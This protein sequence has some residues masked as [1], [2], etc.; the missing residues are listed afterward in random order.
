MQKIRLQR[1]GGE[2]M[3]LKDIAKE[4][5][6]SISTVS[7][8]INGNEHGAASKATRDRIWAVVRKNGYTPNVSAQNLKRKTPLP[9]T[10]VKPLR[11]IDCLQARTA[12][13]S[14]DPFFADLERALEQEAFNNNYV[15]KH[16]FRPIDLNSPATPL[17]PSG[18]NVCGLV[19]FGRY[20]F[21]KQQLQLLT[22]AYKNIIYVG[23]NTLPFKCDQVV[24]DGY[25]AGLDAISY[26]LE[27]G[28]KKIAYIG[29]QNNEC[30]FR[31]YK[32]ALAYHNLPF[33]IRNTAN[34]LQST[35]GGHK[36]VQMLLKQ[37]SDFSAVFCANDLTAIGAI[38]AFH[39]AKLH[40]PRDVSVISVDDIDLSQ[41]M[42][43]M[44]T[45]V[46]IPIEELGR[47]TARL[48]ID[49]ISGG[50]SLPMKVELPFYIAKRDS[51]AR[52]RKSR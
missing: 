6:V 23:L 45:T 14:T 47:Q 44:L 46:H 10:S 8:V 15:V 32:D 38:K 29:E 43:P 13:P 31:A 9:D 2:T 12:N 3:T 18:D 36:G 30:R 21:T 48:L 22:R 24:C 4:A 25:K 34:V 37:N 7:R 33:S 20:L 50:H 39:E 5:G 26:L 42:N 49:R 28:H 27:L 35:E 41:Y 1:N 16:T 51:C 11:Y 52:Y 40:V 19:I 17:R